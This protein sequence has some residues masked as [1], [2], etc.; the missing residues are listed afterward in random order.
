MAEILL[1]RHGRPLCEYGTR[2]RAPDFS[3]WVQAYEDAPID[4]ALPPPADLR[5]RAQAAAYIVTSTQRRARESAALLAPTRPYLS[6]PVFDEAKIP[7]G[8]NLP[9]SLRPIHWIVLARLA[10]FCG[11]SGQVESVR[12]VRSRAARAAARLVALAQAHSPV[13]LV[14]HG[15]LNAL[16]RHELRRSGWTRLRFQSGYW[17]IASLH[18]AA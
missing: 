4:V 6:E 1:V 7:T 15:L 8:I 16:I 18:R 10:W 12:E 5:S 3:G 9:L 11:W 14:G 13:M 2:V 17:G